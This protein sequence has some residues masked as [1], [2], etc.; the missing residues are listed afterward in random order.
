MPSIE[1]EGHSDAHF[2]L[3]DGKIVR[4]E[5]QARG[6]QPAGAPEMP[7]FDRQLRR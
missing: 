5:G 3:I 6:A 4:I 2:A 1:L 7:A